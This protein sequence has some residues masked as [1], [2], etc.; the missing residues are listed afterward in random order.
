[1]TNP[2]KEKIIKEF[3]DYFDRAVSECLAQC[4]N[5]NTHAE[6]L[7]H[8]L[9]PALDRYARE[10]IDKIMPETFQ[11]TPISE[12]PS[13]YENQAWLGWNACREEIQKRADKL[14]E[15]KVL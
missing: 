1:M 3:P 2:I 8:F 13:L 7:S 14:L 9:S 15:E 4:N 12:R 5:K 6:L 10:M 11:N